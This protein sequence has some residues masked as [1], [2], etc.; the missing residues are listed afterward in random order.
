[1]IN[2]MI[3]LISGFALMFYVVEPKD[4]VNSWVLPYGQMLLLKHLS[5]IPL[6]VFAFLNGVLTRK[7]LRVSSFDPRPWIKGRVLLFSLFF[8]LQV[9]WELYRHPTKLNL[10]SSRKVLRFGWNGFWGLTFL[11]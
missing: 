7:S 4:Y 1:M 11:L 6:L 9:Y 8:V 5:I 2:L 3:L 10:R